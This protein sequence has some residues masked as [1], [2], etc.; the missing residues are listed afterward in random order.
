MACGR[1]TG[2]KESI[3]IGLM[4]I[5]FFIIRAGIENDDHFV[6]KVSH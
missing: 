5:Y 2:N 1:V 6:K 4:Y 3:N